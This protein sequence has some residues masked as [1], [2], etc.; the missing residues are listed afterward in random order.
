M[1]AWL[2][3]LCLAAAVAPA[4]ARCR[5]RG[6]A[7]NTS[8]AWEAEEAEGAWACVPRAGRGRDRAM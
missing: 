7:E 5:A 6:Q 3:A 4:P 1:W 8:P 2:R